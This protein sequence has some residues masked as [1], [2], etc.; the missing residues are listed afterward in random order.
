MHYEF[1]NNYNFDGCTL[2]LIKLVYILFADDLVLMANSQIQLQKLINELD[3]YCIKFGV[4]VNLK[5][6]KIIVFINGGILRHYEKWTYRDK[7]IDVVPYFKYLGIMFSSRGC[8][9]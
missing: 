2:G 8:G 1:N 4:T 5:K 7:T 3:K 6:S 9:Q